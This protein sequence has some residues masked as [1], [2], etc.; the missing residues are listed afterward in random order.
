MQ[1]V[2]NYSIAEKKVKKNNQKIKEIY[3]E[4]VTII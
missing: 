1:I 3:R 4:A 2:D